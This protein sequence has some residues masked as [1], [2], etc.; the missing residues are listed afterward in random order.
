MG[1]GADE[2]A[3]RV[4]LATE[5]GVDCIFLTGKAPLDL[6]TVAHTATH[7]PFIVNDRAPPAKDGLLAAG[8]RILYEGHQPFFVMVQALSDAYKTQRNGD[9]AALR[10]SAA[11]SE[12]RRLAFAEDEYAAL[13]REFL[14]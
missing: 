13:V 6:L 2:T 14:G 5:A 9:S 12:V 7:L 11:S 10:S 3:A 1:Q 8:V 4:R